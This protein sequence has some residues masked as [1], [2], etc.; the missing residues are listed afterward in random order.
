MKKSI[1][2][3][4]VMI[5]SLIMMLYGLDFT[6]EEIK[7]YMKLSL[8]KNERECL[9]LLNKKRKG[10]LDEV[11]LKEKQL[12]RIEDIGGLTNIVPTEGIVFIYKGNE[13]KLTGLFSPI[14]QIMGFLKYSNR[15]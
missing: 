2:S 11:H 10:I 14:N 4:F 15:K 9:K 6:V 13:Y 5:L 3:L 1:K 12:S 8:E 7:K